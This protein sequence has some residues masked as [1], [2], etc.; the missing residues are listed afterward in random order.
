MVGSG[1]LFASLY[2]AQIA[3]PAAIISWPIGGF[4]A[5][6]LYFDAIISP[7]GT[8]LAYTGAMRRPFLLVLLFTVTDFEGIRLPAG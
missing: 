3:G 5:L 1:W 6:A 7:A 8:G 2:A 4:V